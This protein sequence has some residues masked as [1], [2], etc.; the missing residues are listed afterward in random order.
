MGNQGTAAVRAALREIN[1]LRRQQQW[2]EAVAAFERLL[3]QWPEAETESTPGLRADVC[4]KSA[5]L[6]R[7]LGHYDACIGR[8]LEACRAGLEVPRLHE[9]LLSLQTEDQIQQARTCYEE[10]S[11]R[12]RDQGCSL[13][14]PPFDE[15]PFTVLPLRSG[16]NTYLVFDREHG[17]IEGTPEWLVPTGENV[18][19][20]YLVQTAW[21]L[22]RVAELAES[23][24]KHRRRIY[25]LADD[26]PRFC[27]F[28]QLPQKPV[29]WTTVQA[30]ADQAELSDYLIRTGSYLPRRILAENNAVAATL[31]TRLQQLHEQRLRRDGRNGRNVLLTIAIPTWNRGHRALPGVRQCLE[32]DFD[33]EV[34]FLISDNASDKYTEEYGQI[35]AMTDAR[36][37]YHRNPENRQFIGNIMTVMRLAQGKFTMLV[38]DED[39]VQVKHLG[40]LLAQLKGEERRTALLRTSLPSLHYGESR[41]SRGHCAVVS[42]ILQ[43]NYLTGAVYNTAMFAESGV[44]SYILNHLDNAACFFYAH[45]VVDIFMAQHGDIAFTSLTSCN[46]GQNEEDVSKENLAAYQTAASR[47]DQHQ[48]YVEVFADVIRKYHLPPDTGAGMLL[49]LLQKTNALLMLNI[50]LDPQCVYW[51]DYFDY[52]MKL[53]RLIEDDNLP[54]YR[55]L[56]DREFPP[57]FHDLIREFFLTC[58]QR[59]DW[60]KKD[61]NNP[62]TAP[63]VFTGDNK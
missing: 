18:F 34:E 53:Y 62:A 14:F 44:E 8:L 56:F 16:E 30:F 50:S 23:A 54:L 59:I 7:Q 48:G 12:W 51:R 47:I 22:P 35:A 43:N 9:F 49:M 32:T 57:E 61:A 13:A 38:S 17:L 58:M 5:G 46:M 24:A 33:E 20:D 29:F 19:S 36:V 45:M 63:A 39:T 55:K 52:L 60:Q 15:L 28:L 37:T 41:H 3:S 2:P 42:G 4:L 11:N 10:Q 26:W 21:N 31:G 1:D 40:S 6:F 27:S 25:L